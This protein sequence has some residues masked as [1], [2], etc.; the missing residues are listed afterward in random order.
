[1]VCLIVDSGYERISNTLS[2]NST[3]KISKVALFF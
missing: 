3:P 2:V 1:M